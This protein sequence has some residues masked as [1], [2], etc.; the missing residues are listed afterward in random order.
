MSEA[1][2]S[3]WRTSSFVRHRLHELLQGDAGRPEG[4]NIGSEGQH[5]TIAFEAVEPEGLRGLLC[6]IRT[7][8]PSFAGELL[9]VLPLERAGGRA[10]I[11]AELAASA[12]Q[13]QIVMAGS[14]SQAG[15]RN[16]AARHAVT[17]W[18]LWLRAGAEFNANL[19][20]ALQRDFGD[21]GCRFLALRADGPGGRAVETFDVVPVLDGDELRVGLGDAP[22][23]NESGAFL[24]T[25][26][27]G[28]GLLFDA[29]G[30]L[31]LGGW[32]ET[33][34][35]AEDLDLSIRL[36]QAGY[37]IGVASRG[38]LAFGVPGEAWGTQIEREVR[39]RFEDKHGLALDP[40]ERPAPARNTA[41]QVRRDLRPTLHQDHR[42][43]VSLV[44]DL[45]DWAFANIAGQL[46]ATLGHRFDFEIIPAALVDELPRLFM[47]CE[48][49]DLLH[50]FWRE[51]IDVVH[52]PHHREHLDKIGLGFEEFR[53]RY[54][55]PKA[56]TTAV[57]DHLFLAPDEVAARARL[58]TELVDSYYVCSRRLFDV[59]A[60]L[61]GY[62]PPAAV[63]PDGVDLSR[64]RPRDLGRFVGMGKRPIKV[65]WVGNSG[66]A[67]H[68]DD[69]KGLHTLLKPALD[70]LRA[71]G[72]PVEAHFADRQ[73]RMIPHEEMPAY[74]G[75]I[76]VLAC[77]SR[78]EGTPNPVLE[79][80]ACGIPV[81][82]TDV[83]I[84]PQAF[85]ERQRAFI[86]PER[87][88]PALKAALRRFHTD[89]SLFATLS[90]ENLDS[91]RAWDWPLMA[92]H[93]EP[94]FFDALKAKRRR[95]G[96][97]ERDRTG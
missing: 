86:L 46:V 2:P 30:L 77:T 52:G 54:V 14:A 3:M 9:A 22:G 37:K 65:G 70:S 96:E 7:Y 78:I 48:G 90:A 62:K 59:Y 17:G 32:D 53:T 87:S 67:A 40:P 91:I 51:I 58:F 29:A 21:L 27:C 84:V 66:W 39:A 6:S 81:I 74:Y 49:S 50:F 95:S 88:V 80:M 47:M 41:A 94:F 82:S 92:A 83:G 34:K 76:D 85:G 25:A 69:P 36:H 79:A 11:E 1:A 5:L 23:R 42:P 20:P 56:I 38:G 28:A 8:L 43:R 63:L 12:K 35:G 45:D 73:V 97:V 72:V 75:Q 13:G 15:L 55:A 18:V 60:A 19:L 64:F 26:L 24:A 89:R 16:A 61:P 68:L 57:Y 10:D 71:E 93:F 44:V 4:P 33:L 31:A